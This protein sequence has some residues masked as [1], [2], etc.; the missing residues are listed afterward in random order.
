MV[1]GVGGAVSAPHCEVGLGLC[2]HGVC[3]PF[4]HSICS[5]PVPPG[6]TQLCPDLWRD[7]KAS[8]G[9]GGPGPDAPHHGCVQADGHNSP[10]CL[11]WALGSAVS[12]FCRLQY[13]GR[14]RVRP[15]LTAPGRVA[16]RGAAGPGLSCASSTDPLAPA[17]LL[18]CTSLGR[19]PLGTESRAHP[20]ALPCSDLPRG[21]PLRHPTPVL[22]ALQASSYLWAS[23][24]PFRSWSPSSLH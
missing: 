6:S 8:R 24:G 16:P 1:A 15:S 19:G 12:C 9:P 22:K 18:L 23:F 3:G 20:D 21:Q 10:H 17:L 4:T 7:A 2:T 13:P 11:H 14:R 5:L